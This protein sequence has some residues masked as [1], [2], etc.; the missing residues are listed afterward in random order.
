MKKIIVPID[1]SE[2]AMNGLTLA[3]TLANH[4]DATIQMVYVQRRLPDLGHVGIEEEKRIALKEF[5][6][7]MAQYQP[8]LPKGVSLEC[9]I[10]QGRVYREIVAQAEAFEDAVI[11][12]STHGASGFEEFFLGSNTLRILA[13]SECPVYTIIEGVE[14][15]PI[16]NIVLPIDT[17][18]ECRQKA[19]YTAKLA[20]AWGAT[21]HL[22]S[23]IETP[24][25][26]VQKKVA[27]FSKQL[28]D[29]FAER[30]IPTVSHTSEGQDF[31]E[32][33]INYTIA[34]NSDLITIIAKD[35]D[36]HHLLLIGDKAQ[37]LIS[38]A[39]MPVLVLAPSV[40]TIRQSFNSM[41]GY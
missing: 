12:T 41:G 23:V 19:P 20:L 28:E 11:V 5:E 16:R 40:D 32:S 21:V 38:R 10:K 3:I 2:E 30:K 24:V 26:A 39:P 13:A 7:L 15:R 14:P 36:T 29:Y 8:T 1:F 34:T 6:K 35:R 27:S 31:I 33:I 9:I 25:E 22:L 4:F 18:I 17:T 37:R